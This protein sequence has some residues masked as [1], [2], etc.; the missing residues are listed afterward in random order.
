MSTQEVLGGFS[1][2]LPE[3]SGRTESLSFASEVGG[4]L[5]GLKSDMSD[6]SVIENWLVEEC[7]TSLED[8]GQKCFT[9]STLYTSR[10]R[11][12]SRF[13]SSGRKIRKREQLAG[14]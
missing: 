7:D 2:V 1:N 12:R 4:S 9:T 8:E 14:S 13:I 3:S 11:A 5:G 10:I 6:N